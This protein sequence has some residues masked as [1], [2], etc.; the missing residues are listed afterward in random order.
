MCERAT[1]SPRRRVNLQLIS[2]TECGFA[3]HDLFAR[4][5]TGNESL[6]IQVIHLYL[7]SVLVQ[8][9]VQFYRLTCFQ[10]ILTMLVSCVILEMDRLFCCMLM[11]SC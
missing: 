10:Y 1:V 11:T 7:I 2:E 4:L 5:K 9:K 3:D 6:P 8:D